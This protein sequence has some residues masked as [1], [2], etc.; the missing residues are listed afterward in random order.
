MM[1][2]ADCYCCFES[3]SSSFLLSFHESKKVDEMRL[4]RPGT[5]FLAHVGRLQTP[6]RSLEKVYF[7]LH[8]G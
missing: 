4:L 7:E 3:R 2:N 6:H 8:F 1:E 5:N